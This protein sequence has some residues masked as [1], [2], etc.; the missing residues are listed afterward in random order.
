MFFHG[1]LPSKVGRSN[2]RRAVGIRGSVS[3]GL[4]IG[5]GGH[6]GVFTEQLD[7]IGRGTEA[8]APCDFGDV[9]L[10][11]QKIVFRHL[12]PIG[13]EVFVKGFSGLLPDQGAEIIRMVAEFGGDLFV[14]KGRIAVIFVNVGKNSF[15]GICLLGGVLLADHFQKAEL[16]QCRGD[17]PI[18]GILI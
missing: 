18:A 15:A 5:A 6:G 12:Q 10:G 16:Q 9:I 2:Y 8:A 11:G 7:E 1:N 4:S 14:G 13:D 3:D 17:F